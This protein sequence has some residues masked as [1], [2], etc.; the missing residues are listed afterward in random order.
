MTRISILLLAV[1]GLFLSNVQA[2]RNGPEWSA[3]RL[4]L[5][6]LVPK[7]GAIMHSF[8]G[9]D[10]MIPPK[11]F[12]ELSG[13]WIVGTGG[14]FRSGDHHVAQV[15]SSAT[16]CLLERRNI[17]FT[18]FRAKVNIALDPGG[19]ERA[20]GLFFRKFVPDQFMWVELDAVRNRVAA[21]V[22]D[23]T[24]EQLIGEASSQFSRRPWQNLYVR[25]EGSSLQVS[26]NKKRVLSLT[27][28]A[29]DVGTVGLMTRGDSKA[30][31]DELHVAV[32]ANPPSKQMLKNKERR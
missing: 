1:S 8:A 24:G 9:D 5:L 14:N 17:L 16:L 7:Y 26:V 15:A 21:F 18:D 31:F 19:K 12:N 23:G 29:I 22:W 11:A 30:R 2:E 27:M 10:G 28:P 3:Y 13:K 32:G 25:T 20:A 4:A 6:N